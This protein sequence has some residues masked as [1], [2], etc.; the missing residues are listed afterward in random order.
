MQN[1]PYFSLPIAMDGAYQRTVKIHGSGI[2]SVFTTTQPGTLVLRKRTVSDNPVPL[3]SV[4]PP[5]PYELVVPPTQDVCD[6]KEVLDTHD[7]VVRDFYYPEAKYGHHGDQYRPNQF[8]GD[9]DDDRAPEFPRDVP[10]FPVV[11]LARQIT[12]EDADHRLLPIHVP[13]ITEPLEIPTPDKPYKPIYPLHRIPAPFSYR[14]AQATHDYRLYH[15]TPRRFPIPGIFTRRLLTLDPACV[16]LEKYDE[17]DVLALYEHDKAVMRMLRDGEEPYPWWPA[18]E[19]RDYFCE[20]T[21]EKVREMDVIATETLQNAFI[22][23]EMADDN[24]QMM[25]EDAAMEENIKNGRVYKPGHD[26]IET[27]G[28]DYPDCILENGLSPR[29][30]LKILMKRQRTVGMETIFEIQHYQALCRSVGKEYYP[31]DD[32][33][34]DDEEEDFQIYGA[35]TLATGAPSVGAGGSGE[36]REEG[37]TDVDA[38]GKEDPKAIDDLMAR[39]PPQY[40]SATYRAH[41]FGRSSSLSSS[42]T[43]SPPD[44]APKSTSSPRRKRNIDDV[45]DSTQDA[46]S[47]RFK[48]E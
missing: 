48:A 36:Q 46:S 25:E 41:M 47:K 8:V 39:L 6:I 34:D 22:M 3:D 27:A 9:E 12:K 7:I 19:G 18:T 17:M 40:T 44:P 37:D 31:E 14:M 30:Y 42:S 32:F 2:S 20:V 1:T 28:L 26:T 35:C 10:P 16:H 45:E 29:Q 23:Q 33:P 5:K 4:A 43:S 21:T 15:E 13:L 38:D 24:R 11:N